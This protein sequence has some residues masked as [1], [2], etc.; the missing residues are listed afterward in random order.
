ME[1]EVGIAEI[2]TSV[3]NIGAGVQKNRNGALGDNPP[4]GL[5]QNM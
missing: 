1:E 3:Q 4:K 2:C 5:K